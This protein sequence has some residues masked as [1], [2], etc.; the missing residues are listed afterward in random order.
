LANRI[1]GQGEGREEKKGE[2]HGTRTDP[3][4]HVHEG[5]RE[6]EA[7]LCLKRGEGPF[8]GPLSAS[9]RRSRLKKKKKGKVP[10]P[11]RRPSSANS[12]CLGKEK[13]KD[14]PPDSLLCSIR[15][16]KKGEGKGGRVEKDL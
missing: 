5:K 9:P 6:K 12:G 14:R 11:Y 13:E 4:L 7:H 2:K 15:K 8:H 1:E 3:P 16:T 10:Q